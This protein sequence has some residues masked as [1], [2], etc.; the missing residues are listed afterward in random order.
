[1]TRP[2]R[3]SSRRLRRR[4][5]A[6]E[7]SGRRNAMRRSFM[8]STCGWRLGPPVAA[9]SVGWDR[10]GDQ[11]PEV[12]VQLRTPEVETSDPV[13]LDELTS[14]C[15]PVG[16]N[17]LVEGLTWGRIDIRLGVGAIECRDTHL[18]K[19][20]VGGCGGKR[21]CCEVRVPGRSGAG[22]RCARGRCLERRIGVLCESGSRMDSAGQ[23]DRPNSSRR[24]TGRRRA[25]LA[26]AIADGHCRARREAVQFRRDGESG[27][28]VRLRHLQVRLEDSF[29]SS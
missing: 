21:M 29:R 1:M 2:A 18:F 8:R 22:H 4:S 26:A 9:L 23:S 17:R 15:E 20:L 10:V 14:R 5:T 19:R 11:V 24:S 12:E 25:C 6:G 3:S 27:H 16:L 28:P 7:A 13:V